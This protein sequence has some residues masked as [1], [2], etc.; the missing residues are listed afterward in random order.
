MNRNESPFL[1]PSRDAEW[2]RHERGE[3]A[4]SIV[5]DVVSFWV[6]FSHDSW[7]LIGVQRLPPVDRFLFFLSGRLSPMFLFFMLISLF[8]VV[9]VDVVAA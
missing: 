7:R 9:V 4:P 5:V 6:P 1:R 3:N 8:V 2:R